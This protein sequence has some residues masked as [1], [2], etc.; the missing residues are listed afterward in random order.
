MPNKINSTTS[1]PY[2]HHAN[3]RAITQLSILPG[4]PVIADSTDDPEDGEKFIG[5]L[6]WPDPCAAD[7]VCLRTII[8]F[9]ACDADCDRGRDG[10]DEALQN[11]QIKAIVNHPDSRVKR[12]CSHYLLNN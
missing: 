8:G 1:N 9:D 3:Y 7:G 10:F 11:W 5:V 4:M 2:H 6:A 12:F